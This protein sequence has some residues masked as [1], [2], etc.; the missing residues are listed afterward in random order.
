[1]LLSAVRTAMK[2]KTI[3]LLGGLG[4]QATM[5]LEARI[6]RVAQGRIPPRFNGGY[7]P[8]V[9]WYCRYPP[10][11]INEQTGEATLP[12]EADPRLLDAA[13]RL[14]PLVDFVILG[15]NGADALRAHIG[16]AAKRPVVSI[17]EATLAEVEQRGWRRVGRE[18]A[19]RAV[20][21]LRRRNVDGIILGC[22]ELPLLLGAEADDSGDLINST[23]MLAEAAVEYAMH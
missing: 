19:R 15:S 17:I 3:G 8:M 6:H 13:Q 16:R 18:A 21:D 9:V 7:P 10:V 23:Q 2:M 11:R 4:P 12:I 20:E 5:D 1:M 14:G 22:T